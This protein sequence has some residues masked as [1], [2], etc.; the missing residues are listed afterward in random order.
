M[1][2]A[3][4]G[5]NDPCPCGSGKKYKQCCLQKDEAA[6]KPPPAPPPAPRPAPRPPAKA[7]PPP[8][9]PEPP[10]P[11]REPTP[12][13]RW[14]GEL[15]AQIEDAKDAD[16]AS[17]IVRRAIEEGPQ[18]PDGA[19]L[20]DI[21][22]PALDRLEEA[23]RH[24]ERMALIEAI[25]ARF[26]DAAREVIEYLAMWRFES[27]LERGDIDLVEEARR[28][29]PHVAV[30][31]D[32][33]YGMPG[34]LAWEGRVPALRALSESAWPAISGGRVLEW[35]VEEWA[36]DSIAAVLL[37]HLARSPDVAPDE[38][39]LLADLAP[40]E[41]GA[42]DPEEVRTLA[43]RWLT[44]LDARGDLPVEASVVTRLGQ[45]DDRV[46]FEQVS[47]LAAVV[48]SRLRGA[49]GWS[50]SR[51]WLMQRDMAALLF[52][53]AS[54]GAPKRKKRDGAPP[55]AAVLLPVPASFHEALLESYVSMF[56][57]KLHSIAAIA[58]ALPAWTAEVVAR[59]WSSNED[60]ARWLREYKR[61]LRAAL[62]DIP[63]DR[64][65]E[66]ERTLLAFTEGA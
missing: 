3:K 1:S 58:L 27:A 7:A 28:F 55:P 26:P 16:E 30:V 64:M 18:P 61:A 39:A 42:K 40:F 8:A 14:W 45:D 29:G 56:S 49:E 54:K 51:A 59:G 5:R 21:L 33:V 37:D 35:A 17:A 10:E 36:T 25:E 60:A 47:N 32:L 19:W 34:R 66:L 43:R 2:T 48:A 22:E 41:E 65:N 57:R 11:P 53:C 20:M 46:A 23:G 52:R 9:P 62:Q 38:P 31:G 15:G 44:L 12:E 63:A 6:R 13:E 24:A 50:R 4:T